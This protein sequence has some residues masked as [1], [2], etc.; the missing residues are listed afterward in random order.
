MAAMKSRN[1]IV[2]E[3]MI[4]EIQCEVFNET[5]HSRL[6]HYN[7]SQRHMIQRSN[8]IDNAWES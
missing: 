3:T 7:R 1:F 2:A 4:R 5:L 6:F 8:S